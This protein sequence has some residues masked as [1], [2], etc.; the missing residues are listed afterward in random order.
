MSTRAKPW[1]VS[2]ASEGEDADHGIRKQ[3]ELFT[4]YDQT[5][6]RCSFSTM[7]SFGI[8]Y[9]AHIAAS[10]PPKNY[11]R[12]GSSMSP[13]EIVRDFQKAIENKQIF[14]HYQPQYNHST[15]QMIGA[16]ALMRWNHP[17]YG[18]QSPA[19]FIPVLEES[20]LIHKADLC[21]FEMLCAFQ[22]RC[23]SS[24]IKPLPISFN[25]SRF[26]FYQHDYVA[27]IEEIRKRYSI[28]VTLLR[29][30]ITETAAVTGTVLMIT[31]IQKLHD[32]GYYVEMDDFGA[33]YSS[34]NALKDLPVDAIKLDMH[35]LS[36]DINGKGGTII[37]S[38]IQMAKWMSIATIAEGVE[39]VQQADFMR[40]IGCNYIQGFL[41]SKPMPEEE[42]IELLKTTGSESIMPPMEL[43]V[44]AVNFWNPDSFETLIFSKYVGAAAV[45]SFENGKVEILRVNPKYVTEMGM[46]LTEDDYV[47]VNPWEHQSENSRQIYEDTI[48][49]A[50]ASGKEETCETWRRFQSEC[51]GEQNICI[52]SH[53]QVLGKSDEQVILY[54]RIRNITA[55]KQM[56]DEVSESE[57]RFRFASEQANVYAWEYDIATKEMRPCFRCMRDLGLP[58]LVKN[59]PEP[60]IDA[61][62]FPQDYADMYRDWHRQL[63]A[64]V[65]HLE[66]II[67]LTVGRVPFHVRYTNSFDENGKPVKAFASATLVVDN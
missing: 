29:A 55:E 45:F 62:I 64:G 7:N 32:C 52:R 42:L 28:P 66:A 11:I 20:G 36:G 25:I 27:E 54:A 18:M 1:R 33:G 59:Y 65:E 4:N 43:S 24:G 60:V 5:I 63:E 10:N 56:Y 30:E 44:N 9:K 49:R 23:I 67:P 46:D 35:F 34:L 12:K 48:R 39:T 13:Q 22:Q 14:L 58:P 47:R 31:V 3:F 16:E 15:H 26:D 50:I 61:G 41:Y 17:A 6:Q 57:R 21:A 40:S 37:K 19:E 53:I 2:A 8:Y 51:C 38:V